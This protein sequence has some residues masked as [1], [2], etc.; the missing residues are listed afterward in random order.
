MEQTIKKTELREICDM[1]L[2]NRPDSLYGKGINFA[3]LAILGKFFT[4]EKPIANQEEKY[5]VHW[6]TGPVIC[7]KEHAEELEGL[8]RF[9]GSHIV[10]SVAPEGGECS[11][12]RNEGR[13]KEASN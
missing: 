13:L 8:G 10:V 9:L 3:V 5:I 6:A 1:L 7:C 4:G 11:N 12:C 2:K